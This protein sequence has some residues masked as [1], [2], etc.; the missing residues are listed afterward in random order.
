[1]SS[2]STALTGNPVS[3]RH[4]RSAQACGDSPGRHLPPGNSEHP[5]RSTPA[6]RIP[7]RNW[8]ACSTMA[9]PMVFTGRDGAVLT[10]ASLQNG[11]QGGLG[12]RSTSSPRAGRSFVR[13]GKIPL[14]SQHTHRREV[15]DVRSETGRYDARPQDETSRASRQRG[16]PPSHG[17]RRRRAPLRPSRRWR[18]RSADTCRSSP[19]P[20]PSHCGASEP[21]RGTA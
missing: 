8:P 18:D 2:S 3:S 10:G 19:L 9:M 15:C 12:P 17:S 1:L 21:S 16:E 7:T 14:S 5:A 4:S 6:G 13:A 11:N 20:R